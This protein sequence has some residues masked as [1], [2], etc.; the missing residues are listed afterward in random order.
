MC[1]IAIHVCLYALHVVQ[2]TH[3]EA[4]VLDVGPEH[5]LGCALD[6]LSFSQLDALECVYHTLLAR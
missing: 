3:P 1:A 2:V 4:V 6:D 5:I